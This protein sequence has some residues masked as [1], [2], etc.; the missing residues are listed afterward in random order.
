[1]RRTIV[2]AIA[3]IAAMALSAVP[4][5]L[6]ASPEPEKLSFSGTFTVDDFCGTGKAV[7]IESSFHGT[8]FVNPNQSGYEFWLTLMGKDVF[9]N[10]ETGETVSIHGAGSQRWAFLHDGDPATPPLTMTTDLGLRAQIVYRGAGG[11]V[12][13]DAGYVVQQFTFTIFDGHIV[14]EKGPHPSLHELLETGQDT[15]CDVMTSALRLN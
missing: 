13:R 9:T 6:A 2:L 5:A 10:V 14:V 1:M 12:T 7:R 11:L 4:A 15:F 3:T 8:L